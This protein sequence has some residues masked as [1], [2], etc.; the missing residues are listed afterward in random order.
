MDT[1]SNINKMCSSAGNYFQGPDALLLCAE[2]LGKKNVRSVCVVGGRHALEAAGEKLTAQLAAG[3]VRYG[4]T[5]FAGF[6][7][8]EEIHDL[9]RRL[10]Q[11]HAD[12][13]IA[14][15]GGKVMDLCKAA[16]MEAGCR[17]F[18]VPTSA[19]TCAAFAALSVVYN[20]LGR[21]S[22]TLYHRS[23][24]DGVFVD[25]EILAQAP[26]RLLA[27]GM[28]DAMAKSCEYSSMRQTLDY[29]DVD[30]AKYCGYSMAKCCD[31][32]LLRCGTQAY[33]DNGH[34]TQSQSLQDA[35][36]V[37]IAAT[38]CIS[39]MG[40]FGGRTGSRFAIAHGFNEVLRGRYV[41]THWWLHGELVAVGIL[42]QLHANGLPEE[43]IHQV[44][45]FYQSIQIPV[46]L[47]QLGVG[48]SNS[49]FEILQKELS[50][51]SGVRQEYVP[52]VYEAVQSVR[53]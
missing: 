12:A 7:T 35:I 44:R 36:Y 3:G 24:V 42:A 30:I 20:D 49:D 51:H 21:Q 27:A 6:C 13:V 2:E 47:E 5:E 8:Q 22:H 26:P 48:L 40:G 50:V 38:G 45:D 17:V 11:N 25:T 31:S 9:A 15:G 18:T 33:L 46:T 53:A 32:V 19:A 28:A 29:G 34:H 52:R 37:S 41:D 1:V 10:L 16:A 43:K 23:G 39:N 4:V 14:V